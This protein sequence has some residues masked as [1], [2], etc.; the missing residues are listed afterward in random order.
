[1]MDKIDVNDSRVQTLLGLGTAA[2]AEKIARLLDKHNGHL[3]NVA[4][5]LLD[6]N[7][8]VN[9]SD[10]RGRQTTK[11][12]APALP[13][14]R[15]QNSPVDNSRAL[16][17]IDNTNNVAG[18]PTYDED[19]ELNKALALSLVEKGGGAGGLDDDEPPPLEP[20]PPVY[21]PQRDPR[22]TRGLDESTDHALRQAL[23]ASLNDGKN[24]LAADV[25]E[26]LPIDYQVKASDGRPTALRSSDPNSIFAP[27]ALQALLSVP[28]LLRRLKEARARPSLDVGE[29]ASQAEMEGV[30]RMLDGPWHD[31]E[32]V[33]ELFTHAECTP[34]AYIDIQSWAEKAS[35][36]REDVAHTPSLAALELMKRLTR[37][38]NLSLPNGTQPLFLPTLHDPNSP[39]PPDPLDPPHIEV[40]QKHQETMLYVVPLN[41][42]P[43]PS[44]PDSNNLIDILETQVSADRVGFALLPEALAFSV[45]GGGGGGGKFKF[46]ARVWMDR[47]MV[48]KR[49]FVEGVVMRRARE[50]EVL[51]KGMAEE[52]EKL[53]RHEGRD[54]LA[55]LRVCIK[56]FE[57]TASDGGDEKRRDRNARTLEKL[58]I[59][60]KDFEDRCEQIAKKTEEL[61]T[62]SAGLWTRPELMTRAYDLQAVIIHDGLL[63]RTHLFTYVRRAG[64][65][66]KIVDADVSEVNEE[67]VLADS[68]GVHLGAGVVGLVY[69]AVQTAAE[70]G[71]EGKEVKWPRKDRFKSQ[72]LDEPFLAQLSPETQARLAHPPVSAPAS[73]DEEDE[74]MDA[75]EMIVVA[76]D[77]EVLDDVRDVPDDVSMD[78]VVPP[79]GVV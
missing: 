55:D 42:S 33:R 19:L 61:K 16:V 34:R 17:R 38:L 72:K 22:T 40:S 54:T 78:E 5:A 4:A 59:I 11:A 31:C 35:W 60:L 23:E 52:R 46:P 69:A 32:V 76:H 44:L 47:W 53:V 63:G 67:T 58:K 66:W 21:G 14:R 48:E 12:I 3:D 45:D 27:P 10:T 73:E 56:H 6:G 2:T 9:D 24:S 8:E 1:M 64:K 51:I 79:A 41:L 15:K 37:A 25:Y 18:P 26:E 74:F 20:L 70:V 28:Q 68:S 7:F 29:G 77:A 62:E 65:W 49:E 30:E 57:S 43:S 39:T 36:A 75:E 50:I 13:P 71:Q